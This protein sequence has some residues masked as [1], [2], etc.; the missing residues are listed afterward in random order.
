MSLPIGRTDATSDDTVDGGREGS[1]GVSN[2]GARAKSV[3]CEKSKLQ[4]I[5]ISFDLLVSLNHQPY[6]SRGSN[7]LQLLKVCMV[8]RYICV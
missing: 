7:T 4:K 6:L 1:L 8:G 5:K 3:T 2:I